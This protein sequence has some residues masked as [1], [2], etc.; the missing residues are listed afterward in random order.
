M[1]WRR[2]QQH[3]YPVTVPLCPPQIPRGLTWDAAPSS[4]FITVV[5]ETMSASG[6]GCT[7]TCDLLAVAVLQH[8]IFWQYLC[9]NM[10]FSGSGCAASSSGSSCAATCHLLAVPVLQHI[11]FWQFLCCNMSA[12]WKCRSVQKQSIPEWILSEQ[13]SAVVFAKNVTDKLTVILSVS[14]CGSRGIRKVFYRLSF[15]S[16]LKYFLSPNE[17]LGKCRFIFLSSLISRLRR[18]YIRRDKKP[19]LFLWCMQ[20]AAAGDGCRS[21]GQPSFSLDRTHDD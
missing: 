3:K 1:E 8:V 20:T 18:C 6:S 5:C 4:A 21:C 11:I 15:V 7:A 2:E 16:V 12:V 9:C 14:T 17:W 19:V 10:S 13:F